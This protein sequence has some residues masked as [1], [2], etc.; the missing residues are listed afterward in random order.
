MMYGQFPRFVIA[1]FMLKAAYATERRLNLCRDDVC[2][3]VS[4]MPC[5]AVIE[6]NAFSGNCCSLTDIHPSEG[7]GCTIQVSGGSCAWE[8]KDGSDP[9][10]EYMSTSTDPCPPTQYRVLQDSTMVPSDTPSLVPSFV[11]SII[12]SDA[13]S[14][15]PSLPDDSTPEPSDVE[16]GSR[17]FEPEDEQPSSGNLRAVLPSLFASLIILPFVGGL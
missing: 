10:I 1:C 4:D 11:P 7:G 5:D 15:V 8:P 12:P 6:L 2:A 3:I 16:T 13:P 17:S 14:L 9:G